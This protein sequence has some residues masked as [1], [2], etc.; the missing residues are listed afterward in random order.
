MNTTYT[1]RAHELCEFTYS[2]F[3]EWTKDRY[4]SGMENYNLYLNDY[5]HGL[6]ESREWNLSEEEIKKIIDEA[7]KIWKDEY[8]EDGE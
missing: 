7:E 2:T 5:A 3:C 4:E 1:Q 8:A 6:N